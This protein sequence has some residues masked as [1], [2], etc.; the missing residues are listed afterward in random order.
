MTADPPEGSAPGPGGDPLPAT[1]VVVVSLGRPAQLSLCLAAL[2]LQSHPLIEVVLVADAPGLAVRPD[3]PLKRVPCEVAN[4]AVARNLGI[5][6]AAG[7]VVAFIDDDAVA[8]PPWAER[9]AA[10]FA[11]PR[12]IAAAGATRGPDGLRWQVRAERI[13]PDG[14]QPLH[15]PGDQPR[16]VFPEGGAVLSTIGTNCAFRREALLAADGFDPA[17]AYHL[18]ESDLNLRLA[19]RFPQAPSAFVPLAEVTHGAAPGTVRDAARLPADLAPIGRSAAIFARRH[20]GDPGAEARRQR[21]RLLRL[22][23]AG[24]LD[25][26]RVRPLLATLK[27]GGDAAPAASPL[28]PPLAPDAPPGFQP[29]PTRPRPCRFLSGWHWQARQLRAEAAALAAEGAIVTL[30]LMTPTLLPHRA[31]FTPGGWWEQR[32]GLW[33]PSLP[34]DPALVEGGVRTRALREVRARRPARCRKL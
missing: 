33:G 21:K 31:G 18:D 9:L 24:R 29:L 34:G 4:I 23:L 11:D 17:F 1:S 20:G 19:A 15:A 14:P 32:G 30:L 27:A 7:A 8:E 22:M 3:L 2:T 26:L 13:T 5:A 28:P 16:L 25:P 10:A 12:V 6:A